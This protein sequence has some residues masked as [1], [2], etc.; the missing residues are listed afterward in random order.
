M[1]GMFGRISHLFSITGIDREYKG[2]INDIYA[3]Y[4][5]RDF[6]DKVNDSIYFIRKAIQV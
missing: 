6:S 2:N 5:I 3:N 1:E 4:S